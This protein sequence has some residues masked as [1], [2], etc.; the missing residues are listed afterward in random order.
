MQSGFTFAANKST[1]TQSTDQDLWRQMFVKVAGYC[2]RA[3]QY[4]DMMMQCIT[5]YMTLPASY[6]KEL[7][8]EGAVRCHHADD[9][10]HL[11]IIYSCP[12]LG[13]TFDPGNAI[14]ELTLFSMWPSTKKLPYNR[15]KLGD[16]CEGLLAIGLRKSVPSGPAARSLARIIEMVAGGL[17]SICYRFCLFSLEALDRKYKEIVDQRPDRQ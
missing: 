7:S 17:Y 15:N 9:P 8:R 16:I 1:S 11:I 10:V 6:R 13:N 12:E 4:E 5:Q 3:R 2:N 14:Y